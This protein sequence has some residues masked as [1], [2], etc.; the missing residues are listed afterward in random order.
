MGQARQ[1]DA[2]GKESDM[3]NR[4]TAAAVAFAMAVEWTVPARA[5]PDLAGDHDLVESYVEA[6]NA[7]VLMETT[8]YTY[9]A[10]CSHGDRA[11]KGIAAIAPQW[12]GSAVVLYEAVETEDGYEVGDFLCV[13]E[14]LDTGYGRSTG[15][16]VPSKVRPDK[17]SRG[18][19]EVGRTIDVFC[20]SKEEAADW[21][22]MTG[23]KVMAQVIRGVKG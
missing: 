19:I 1:P 5:E 22:S 7:P 12:Y 8:A 15:D 16:G 20:E 10:V 17:G 11:R 21:M 13:L 2:Q 4:V 3:R 18:T 23:G 6:D 9:G 14:G